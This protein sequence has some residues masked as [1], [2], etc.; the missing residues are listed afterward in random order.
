VHGEE[1]MQAV[2]TNVQLAVEETFAQ[3]GGFS[4]TTIKVSSD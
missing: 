2:S 1:V 3:F 4:V